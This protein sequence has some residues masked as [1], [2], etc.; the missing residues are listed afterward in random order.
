MSSKRSPNAR[1]HNLRRAL[2]VAA[3]A[4]LLSSTTTSTTRTL[5]SAILP[6]AGP[7]AGADVSGGAIVN[8]G[9]D[10]GV[11]VS[12]LRRGDTPGCRGVGVHGPTDNN[13]HRYR[14]HG[15]HPVSPP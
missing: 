5:D 6:S 11:D 15:R 7:S 1:S 3:S 14:A 13:R 4:W 8:K 10:P 2:R 12:D 9:A